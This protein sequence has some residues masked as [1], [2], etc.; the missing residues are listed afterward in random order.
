[1]DQN[2]IVLAT[3]LFFFRDGDAFTVPGAGTASRTSKP[4][5]T[6]TGWLDMGLIEEYSRKAPDGTD[7]E[8]WGAKSGKLQL[9]DVHTVKSKQVIT[10]TA[11]E[12]G[13]LA[14]ELLYRT[15]KLTSASTQFNPNEG[16]DK[17]GWLKI[18]QYDA[19]GTLRITE[20]VYVKLKITGDVDMSGGGLTKA[21]FEA[22]VLYSTLNTGAIVAS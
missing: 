6:D 12:F 22:T 18:Q 16:G 9:N 7:I 17:K 5:A 4:G 13:P 15:L 19:G 2:S 11:N 3:N 21:Q 1:M 8:V 20:D 10:F 14:V